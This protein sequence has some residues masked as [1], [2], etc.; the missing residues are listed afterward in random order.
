MIKSHTSIKAER[1]AASA[2]KQRGAA[3]VFKQRGAALL[4]AMII[5]TLVSTVAAG[6]VWQQS[7][8]IQV[9]AAERARVQAAWI[10]NGA[11]DWARLILREDARPAAGVNGSAANVDHLGEPWAVPLA[12]A[13]LSSFLAAD[14]DNTTESGPEA[15]LSGVINDAQS[16]YNL[17]NLLDNEGKLVPA[18]QRTLQ[19]LCDVAG[20]PADVGGRIAEGLRAAWAPA[21]GDGDSAAPLP[22]SRLQQLAWLGIDKAALQR[23][24]PLVVLLPVRTPINVNTAP[25]EVLVAV[26]DG[27]DLGTA[28]RL[29]QLRQRKAFGSLD[30]LRAQLSP[31]IK[32]EETRVGVGSL[33]FEVFGRLR[34]EDRILEENSLLERRGGDRGAEVVALQR[35]RR[36]VLAVAP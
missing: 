18:E 11:L 24:Q 20:V 26:L 17:R 27:L 35:E 15:F 4:L 1:G 32:T 22:P 9:E 3:R 23:L 6:M 12:E 16:R 30:D 25:R 8:A 31:A 13:R 21:E 36:S 19:R 34:L 33:Y 28:E 29:V 2:V 10:L 14:R 7:R 5:L